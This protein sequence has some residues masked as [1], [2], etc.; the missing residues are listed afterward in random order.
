[1]A[2]TKPEATQ[3][4]KRK[5]KAVG[6]KTIMTPETIEKLEEAFLLGCSDREAC[7]MADIAP[8]TL[9]KYQEKNPEFTER[10][11]QL[12]QSPFIK[13]RQ[14]V[15][16]SFRRDPN[17]ALKYL[18]RKKKDEFS[19]R[20][21]TDVTSGGEKVNIALVRFEDGDRNTDTST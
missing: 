20:T 7:L 4:T 9:Y 14:A 2:D 19:L 10:K 12:K 16:S 6:R 18:E 1:M 5:S 21:E 17:L 8:A 3:V 13:A 15:I 11:E